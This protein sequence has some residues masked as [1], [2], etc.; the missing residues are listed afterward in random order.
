MKEYPATTIE[1]GTQTP[2]AELAHDVDLRHYAYQSQRLESRDIS[3]L[4]AS[5]RQQARWY[6]HFLR[7]LMPQDLDAPILDAPCGHGNFLYFLR[8]MKF[9]NVEGFD[10]DPGRVKLA[11][12]LGLPAN[13][14][15]VTEVLRNR[16]GLAVITM[17]DFLEHVD[18]SEVPGLLSS[19]FS[20]LANNGILI[21]RLPFT[22]CLLGSYDL[23]NDFTHKWAAN[24]GVTKLLF[25]DAGFTSVVV[26]DERPVL[27]KWSN[28]VRSAAFLMTKTMTNLYL[29]ALGL[30]ALSIW[31]RSGFVI[32]RKPIS[33]ASAD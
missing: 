10:I 32:G 28:Y 3:T 13:L 8:A 27:Y 18:R 33:T 7:N 29:Q 30:P 1:C 31:S 26:R 15:D 9:R 17:L 22:D 6:S 19:A 4:E 24:S 21:V 5:F 16:S 12:S 14:G 2:Q 20:A 23:G 11:R 25:E